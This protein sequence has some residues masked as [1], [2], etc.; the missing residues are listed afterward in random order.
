MQRANAPIG[1]TLIASAAAQCAVTNAWNEINPLCKLCGLCTVWFTAAAISNT[2]YFPFP[3]CLFSFTAHQLSCLLLPC[4]VSM[5]N[6]PKCFPL[7]C[8]RG[9]WRGWVVSS[10][11]FFFHSSSL[12]E[13]FLNASLKCWPGFKEVL[14]WA[15]CA[16]DISR[17][18]KLMI[19]LITECCSSPCSK[20]RPWEGN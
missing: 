3:Y 6:L 8:R 10:H 15:D 16:S 11:V 7:L 12:P 4:L 19:A 1:S 14:A 20:I 18:W 9:R 5:W 17:S 13:R 2:P